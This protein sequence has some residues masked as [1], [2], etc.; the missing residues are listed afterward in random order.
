MF[1]EVKLA[2][3]QKCAL[4]L[5]QIECIL[6][7]DD[8]QTIIF[9]GHGGDSEIAWRTNEPYEALIERVTECCPSMN[10]HFRAP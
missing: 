3:G 10:G 2:T 4:N 7:D 5:M 8:G 9:A 6:T 1:I